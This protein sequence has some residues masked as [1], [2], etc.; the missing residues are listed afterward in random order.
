MENNQQ[1]YITN[2][3]NNFKKYIEKLL[4]IIEHFIVIPQVSSKDK[5]A[6]EVLKSMLTGREV[7]DIEKD[8]KRGT[9]NYSTL[10]KIAKL[11][12]ELFDYAVA[13]INVDLFVKEFLK[14]LYYV[15]NERNK[16]CEII[17]LRAL[18]MLL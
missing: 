4:A 3:H 10:N 9:I 13:H 18:N 16:E 12:K 6:I 7:Y 5:H 11:N 8:L 2:F 17:N 15:Q 1:Q 14:H